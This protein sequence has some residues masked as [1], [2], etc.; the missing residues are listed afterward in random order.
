MAN[1]RETSSQRRQ[2]ENRARRAALE[3]RKGAPSRPS[4]VAPATAD[5]LARSSSDAKGATGKAGSAKADPKAT[6]SGRPRRE[7]PPKP[8]DKPVD[9][10]T[11]E[12]SWF[13]KVIQVPGGLQA[14]M[15]LALAVFVSIMASF[16]D[17]YI[18]EAD[19]DKKG[20][21]ATQT[22][23][24]ANGTG[25]ALL[26]LGLP[27]LVAALAA[28][29]SLTKYRRRI[30]LGAA[31]VI[32]AIFGTSLI[33]YLFVAGTFG[34]A[35]FRASKIEGPDTPIL[36]RTKRLRAEA[37]ADAQSTGTDD[38]EDDAEVSR[39]DRS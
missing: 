19:K 6:R 10:A 8:G 7:K 16:T 15:A 22:I 23:F 32:G 21:K 33:L 27:L 36:R 35:V 17:L 2:R 24:E 4:R 11:L 29:L 3:A 12:G 18:S 38:L 34:W 28:G 26:L 5:R 1:K 13:K 39:S 31:V 14:L 20:A 30:W 37:E 9:I 25:R